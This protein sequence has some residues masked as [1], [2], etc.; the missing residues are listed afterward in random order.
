M[1]EITLVL[2][3]LISL[4]SS[5]NLINETAISKNINDLPEKSDHALPAQNVSEE[6][7]TINLNQL[8]NE[9]EMYDYSNFSSKDFFLTIRYYKAPKSDKESSKNNSHFTLKTIKIHTIP[10]RKNNNFERETERNSR[11]V[12]NVEVYKNDENN[13]SKLGANAKEITEYKSIKKDSKSEVT[14]ESSVTKSVDNVEK[15]FGHVRSSYEPLDKL[16]ENT[17]IKGAAESLEQ[18][19]TADPRVRSSVD[20]DEPEFEFESVRK[21]NIDSDT[22]NKFDEIAEVKNITEDLEKVAVPSFRSSNDN[23]G[24]EKDFKSFRS[25][26]KSVDNFKENEYPYQKPNDELKINLTVPDDLLNVRNAI[27][28]SSNIMNKH[29][30]SSDKNGMPVSS[31]KTIIIPEYTP[32]TNKNNDKDK[33]DSSGHMRL[34]PTHR[35]SVNP[36]VFNIKHAN[37]VDLNAL[38]GHKTNI[39]ARYGLVP[40]ELRNF[41][42]PEIYQERITRLRESKVTDDFKP[43]K[44]SVT[45]SYISSMPD[46]LLQENIVHG[47]RNNPNSKLLQT[48]ISRNV[49]NLNGQKLYRRQY[50]T[51]RPNIVTP[52]NFGSYSSL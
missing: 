32:V 43:D 52:P 37:P 24:Y 1:K 18:K 20:N 26:N 8:L 50:N 39:L 28:D 45:S 49:V 22:V 41:R 5:I 46:K 14:A 10:S 29:A 17:K 15:E 7:F 51:F 3:L 27:F 30:K 9:S 11:A 34:F 13:V 33:M 31:L 42:P 23:N 36:S 4:I 16:E 12:Q 38:L 35:P 48:S 47:F 40:V 25:V 6:K 2:Y 44:I 19:V 21:D